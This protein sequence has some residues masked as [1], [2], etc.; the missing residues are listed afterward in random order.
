M[1]ESNESRPARSRVVLRNISSR[2]W[3]HPA[4]RGALVALRR[5]KGF[6]TVVKL[7]NS[8]FR[9]RTYRLFFLGSMVR[10]D[11]RQFPVLH[12]ALND[13]AGILDA[14]VVPELYVQAEPGFNSYCV[15]MDR[16]VIVINSGLVDLLD[17]D[18]LRWVLAHE[19]GHALSGHAVYRTILDRLRRMS[20]AFGAIPVG[21][22]GVRMIEAGLMEWQRKSE[23]SAD[24]AGLLATQDPAV[25]YRALMK[26][27]S[28][29]HLA[30]LDQTSFF[31]QGS[32]Y[33]ATDLRDSVLKMLL[34]E[35]RSHPMPVSRASELRGWVDSG[36]Y[37]TILAG[38]YPTR[39]TDDE[40]KV[41]EAAQDAAR[42]YSEAFRETQDTLGRLVH[43][44]AGWM[45][46]AKTWWDEQWR[47]GGEEDAS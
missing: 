28:G 13:A 33:E 18:E 23:L 9:E 14:E 2:T 15:G 36:A 25:A 30:D 42:S 34:I 45:G 27:A 38:D 16:P 35:R 7:L 32:E 17:E 43:D 5:L 41:S 37:T 26:I 22:L 40:A 46:S 21:G 44:T 6:D 10:V 29:G 1:S 12:R 19:L 3:E 24:R 39:D 31:G 20:G 8:L 11:E 4:D 47:R